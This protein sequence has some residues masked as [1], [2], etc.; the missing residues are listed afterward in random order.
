[1]L[2]F[3][4]WF[5]FFFFFWLKYLL[6]LSKNFFDARVLGCQI[7]D[8]VLQALEESSGGRFQSREKAT[9]GGFLS[10]GFLGLFDGS[11]LGLLGGLRV[12]FN[13]G[14]LG[15]DLAD[16]SGLSFSLSDGLFLFL[17]FLDAG[18]ASL[19]L[20]TVVEV[21]S[22][23]SESLLGDSVDREF[24]LLGG[25]RGSSG[26][27]DLDDG[28]NDSLFGEF[29]GFLNSNGVLA[30]GDF[31]VLGDILSLLSFLSVFEEKEAVVKLLLVLGQ[32]GVLDL[33]TLEGLQDLL[34]VDGLGE[35]RKVKGT[36]RSSD[37]LFDGLDGL[38]G[39]SLSVDVSRRE[40]EILQ[41][42]AVGDVL[43]GR[44][45][46]HRLELF[47]ILQSGNSVDIRSFFMRSFGC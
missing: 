45:G 41:R 1:L 36:R 30:D 11:F 6:S 13:D 21:D 19:S 24:L 10:L 8:S 15:L 35:L 3:R 12:R 5:F 44:G 43:V 39:E 26:L 25:G 17:T 47:E 4:L 46:P 22:V 38:N 37:F 29:V 34:L 20:F 18:E 16:D 7:D 42:I 27:G 2:F 23:G 9:F 31:S 33:D 28:L 14:L 40:G 32:D